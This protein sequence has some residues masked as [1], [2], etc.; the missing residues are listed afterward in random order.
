MHESRFRAMGTDCHLLVDSG[1]VEH[2]QALLDL[3]RTRVELLEQ[4]WSRFQSTSELSRLNG[5]AGTGPIEVSADLLTLGRRMQQAWHLTAGLFD[6]TVLTS[7]LSLGYDADFSTIAAGGAA[8]DIT[9]LPAPGMGGVLIDDEA[10]TISLPHGVGLDPGA[11]GKGLAADIIARELRDAGADGVLVNLGG[12]IAISGHL[13]EPWCVELIDERMPRDAEPRR[14]DVLSFD[15][16]ADRIGIATS[17]TLKRRWAQGRHHVIDPRSGAPSAE[18][19][20]Q[21]TVIDDEAWRAEVL[22]TA[23]LLHD[24]AYAW[25]TEQGVTALLVTADTVHRTPRIGA[26]TVDAQRK[27]YAHG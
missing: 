9:L 13:G 22:A 18:E 19:L 14:L 4:S 21:V 7:M 6:P 17:T 25:L 20:V 26:T 24:D 12:D 10:S 3:A 1:D 2:E 23:A 16:Q 15:P 5:R 27:E 8:T 11:I